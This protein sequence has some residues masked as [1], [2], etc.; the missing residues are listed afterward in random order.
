MR[1][2]VSYR[3]ASRRSYENF[4]LAFPSLPL[5]YQQWASII[6]TF[7]YNFRD[8][9]LESGERAK[10]P[11]GFGDFMVAK[12][13]KKRYKTL[14][15]GTERVN[16]SINWK[17]TREE[18]KY[19]YYLNDHTEG[20]NFYWR[21]EPKSARFYNSSIWYFKPSRISSRL[22]THYLSQPGYQDLYQCWDPNHA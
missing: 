5:T 13:K 6:Y 11:W 20:Y 17:A 22:I 3:T 19:I 4:R 9:L 12:K 7:N 21:W 16:L 18:G 14:P 2:P 10:M 15:D 1:R 8:H